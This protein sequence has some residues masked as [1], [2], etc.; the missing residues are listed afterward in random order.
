MVAVLDGYAWARAQALLEEA[1]ASALTRAL[2]QVDAASGQAKISGLW[3]IIAF[4]VCELSPQA[5]T[6]AS[7]SRIPSTWQFQPPD[8]RQAVIRGSRSRKLRAARAERQGSTACRPGRRAP[9]RHQH[10]IPRPPDGGPE[11]GGRV[12]QNAMQKRLGLPT[13]E[14]RIERAR[15]EGKRKGFW[16]GLQIG[17]AL[18]LALVLIIAKLAE[19]TP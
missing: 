8:V 14:Q 5:P 11:E 15:N 13:T 7:G 16:L 4:A 12:M 9:H 3:R 19:S 1:G 17:C 10:E 2:E 6:S 18:A